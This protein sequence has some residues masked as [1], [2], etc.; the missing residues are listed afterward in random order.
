[1]PTSYFI[2]TNK[3]VEALVNEKNLYK[4][5][6]Y[7]T[8]TISPDELDESDE[9]DESDELDHTCSASYNEK[10]YHIMSYATD[11]ANL[12]VLKRF[13]NKIDVR[14]RPDG[15]AYDLIDLAIKNYVE[16]YVENNPCTNRYDTI[17][18]IIEAQLKNHKCLYSSYPTRRLVKF[19]D[20]YD[21][22]ELLTTLVRKYNVS[23]WNMY[24]YSIAWGYQ[25][26]FDK[27]TNDFKDVINFEW[28]LSA[29]GIALRFEN[30]DIMNHVM[31]KMKTLHPESYEKIKYLETSTEYLIKRDQSLDNLIIG[32]LVTCVK[33][34]FDFNKSIDGIKLPYNLKKIIFG[35]YFNQSLDNV[36][37]PDTVE[38]IGF[39]TSYNWSFFDKSI[40]KIKFPKSL[41]I[42]YHSGG[43]CDESLDDVIFPDSLE[44]LSI[45]YK[46]NQ[47]I[48][49]VKWPSN[50]K[51]IIFGCNFNQSLEKVK[52][53]DSLT[54]LEFYQTK[55]SLA[56]N[57]IN[58]PIK[59]LKL[60]YICENIKRLPSSLE[61]IACYEQDKKRICELNEGCK[62]VR[63]CDI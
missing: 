58:H 30:I 44:I 59:V 17:I 21:N 18:L 28:T 54:E 43:G 25:K 6:N 53:P 2:R 31:N 23:M 41:K 36:V 29:I 56:I 46:F 60:L 55:T 24:R 22:Y 7:L 27:I 19:C 13:S 33:T 15:N 52:F 47:C 3:T 45:G 34:E 32:N 9:S 12:V 37:F 38:Y 10:L 26:V 63:Y 39:G 48:D 40:K 57:T 50:L 51:K 20:E 16:N 8:N 42:F 49:K 62:I 14:Y 4:L 11:T 35:P 5:D 1:M 61:F